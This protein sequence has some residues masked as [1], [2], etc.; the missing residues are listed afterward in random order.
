LGQ[1]SPGLVMELE[2]EAE[3]EVD[4]DVGCC[5][6]F[7]KQEREG[8]RPEIWLE[9]TPHAGSTPTT[10][11]IYYPFSGGGWLWCWWEK[12]V[13]AKEMVLLGLFLLLGGMS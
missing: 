11:S 12:E 13:V 2:A 8:A 10:L 4:V 6:S 9:P 1:G 3:A 7:N 5:Y